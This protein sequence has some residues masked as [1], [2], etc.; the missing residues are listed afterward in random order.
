MH[1]A[2]TDAMATLWFAVPAW[3]ASIGELAG[4]QVRQNAERNAEQYRPG[5]HRSSRQGRSWIYEIGGMPLRG[6]CT[7]EETCNK[8][9]VEVFTAIAKTG[10][11]V[12]PRYQHKVVG[13]AL[14]PIHGGELDWFCTM[15]GVFCFGNELFTLFNYSREPAE[16]FSGKPG[17]LQ[18]FNNH[19]L[20]GKGIVPWQKTNRPQYGE[21]DVRQLTNDLVQMT[22]GA[23]LRGV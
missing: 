23:V 14:Y 17:D 10:E 5:C 22:A 16:R 9:D 20:F 3:G 15:R 7:K 8:S 19:L 13:T 11:T 6:P 21:L 2:A 1:P 12:L 4:I 18:R